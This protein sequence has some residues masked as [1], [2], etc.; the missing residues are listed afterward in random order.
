MH[1][2][3]FH[4]AFWLTVL[5]L[6][7]VLWL[8]PGPFRVVAGGVVILLASVVVFGGYLSFTGGYLEAKEK[9]SV[10]RRLVILVALWLW[11]LV[12]ASAAVFLTP[13]LSFTANVV[14]LSIESGGLLSLIVAAYV[15]G[16]GQPQPGRLTADD[17][18]ELARRIRARFGQFRR[19]RQ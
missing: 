9:R 12:F 19:P 15:S 8:P 10:K 4:I 2:L 3:T 1:R 17:Q 5:A 7:A 6:A 13:R 18:K 16:K 14:L 11:V